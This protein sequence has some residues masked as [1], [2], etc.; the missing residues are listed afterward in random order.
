MKTKAERGYE[1]MEEKVTGLFEKASPVELDPGMTSAQAFRVIARN[2][3][4]QIIA[5]APGVCAQD[6]EA[7]HQ[8]RVGLRRLRAAIT[9]FEKMVEPIASATASRTS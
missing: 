4:R 3:L 1:L 5:N 6:I 8:M 7:V 9:I 2:C